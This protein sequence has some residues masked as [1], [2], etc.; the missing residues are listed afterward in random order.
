M[1]MQTQMILAQQLVATVQL[2]ETL[3]VCKHA[4]FEALFVSCG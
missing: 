4:L 3:K 2:T 1:D